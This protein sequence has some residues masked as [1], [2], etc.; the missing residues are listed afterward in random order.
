MKQTAIEVRKIRK[1][2]GLTQAQLAELTG[3]KRSLIAKYECGAVTPPGDVMLAL[4]R[5][6]FPVRGPRN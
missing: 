5:R 1:E 6:E 4:Q 2:M 3:I